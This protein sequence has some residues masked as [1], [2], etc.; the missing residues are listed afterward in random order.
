[1][2]TALAAAGAV[3]TG[4][5][6][7]MGL[8]GG[9]LMMIFLTVTAGIAQKQAQAINLLYFIPTALCGLVLHLKNGLVDKRAAVWCALLGAAGAVIGSCAALAVDEALLRRLF[10]ALLTALGLY[11]LFSGVRGSDGDNRDNSEE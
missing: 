3:I 8:G 1:M 6:S 11:E 7:S 4:I 2:N 10:G 9:A 5:I